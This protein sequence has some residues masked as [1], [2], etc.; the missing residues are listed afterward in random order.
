[1]RVPT[2]PD[3][4]NAIEVRNERD[5]TSDLMASGFEYLRTGVSYR[6]ARKGRQYS[7]YLVFAQEVETSS[8]DR[9]FAAKFKREILRD[10]I[11]AFD[12]QTEELKS[13]KWAAARV[14]EDTERP[15]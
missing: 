3:D 9:F 1:M 2:H 8:L 12:A 14:I 10:W 6:P 11:E 4:A 15:A 5:T 13:R 7:W